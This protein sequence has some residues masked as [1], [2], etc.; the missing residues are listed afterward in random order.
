MSNNDWKA[1]NKSD[2]ELDNG[3][4]ALESPEH[5]DVSIASNVPRLI[6]PTRT[7]MEQAEKGLMTVTAVETRRNKG[8]KRK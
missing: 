4:E 2:I 8:N 7:S 5:Q 6:R 3:I 1:D